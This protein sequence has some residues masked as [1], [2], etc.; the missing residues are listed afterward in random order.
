MS[1]SFLV[2]GAG[3]WG[4][5]LSIQLIKSK[6]KVFLSSFDEENLRQIKKD[7]ENK[8]YLPGFK[9]QK[10]LSVEPFSEKLIEGVDSIIVCVKSP[11]FKDAL[12]LVKKGLKNKNLLWATKGFDPNSG[13]LLSSMVAEEIGA[14]T[15]TAGLSGTTIE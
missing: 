3:A 12:L 5:A 7:L 1:R 15:K 4:T 8:K 6:N 14:K 10:D 9:L 11:Y 13:G 2:F